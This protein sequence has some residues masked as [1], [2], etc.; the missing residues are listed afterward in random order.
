MD[1]HPG[2]RNASVRA[3]Q[4]CNLAVLRREDFQFVLQTYPEFANAIKKEVNKKKRER[5]KNE[6]DGIER[7]RSQ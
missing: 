4:D 6:K 3:G 5:E 1:S 2:T 7:I